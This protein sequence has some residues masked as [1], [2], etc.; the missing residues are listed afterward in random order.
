[1]SQQ[2]L[3]NHLKKLEEY[4][5]TVLFN[6]RPHLSLTS[7]GEALLSF[8][9]N[10]ISKEQ[11]LKDIISDIESNEK[12]FLRVGASV[13]RGMISLPKII[14][15]FNKRYPNVEIRYINALSL[16]LEALV[17]EGDLDFA[18]MLSDSP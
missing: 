10:M 9:K 17:E 2:T 15:A 3:S 16:E 6:R 5:G 4:Y 12:G 1:I 7:S 18:I 8:A 13:S 11:N 14:P